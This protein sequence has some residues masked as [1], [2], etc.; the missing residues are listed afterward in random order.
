MSTSVLAT[1]DLHHQRVL[2]T[3]IVG[4]GLYFIAH[5][6]IRVAI[7]P[8]LEMDEAEQVFL[9]Q[10]W[11]LGYSPEP[12]PNPQP[13][14]YPW[15]QLACFQI[16]GVGV[17]A[18]SFLKNLLL[19][20]TF[21]LVFLTTRLLTGN[22]RL[23]V[24]AALSLFLFPQ[25]AWESQ[26]DLTHSVLAVMLGA[27]TLLEALYLS[28]AR[29]LS[30]YVL[31]GGLLGL[32][33]MSKYTFL[34]FASA[35]LLGMLWTPDTRATILDKRILVTLAVSVLVTLPHML[36]W[37]SHVQVV[38]SYIGKISQ[39]GDTS[40][41][42]AVGALLRAIVSFF[43]IPCLAYVLLFPSGFRPSQWVRT[44]SGQLGL[45]DRVLVLVLTML[46]AI[47]LLLVFGRFNQRWIQPLLWF[48]PIAFFAHL[49]AQAVSDRAWRWCV[50]G[51]VALAAIILLASAVRVVGL[52]LI[53]RFTPFAR[54]AEYRFLR[55]PARLNYPFDAIAEEVRKHGF[56]QGV[57]VAE[58]GILAGNL[59]LK[60]P[61]SL[62]IIPGRMPIDVEDEISGKS[63]L[64]IWDF[65]E[66]GTMP[67][68]I[69]RFLDE[70]IHIEPEAERV[71]YREFPFK[72]SASRVARI[73]LVF[74]DR[75]ERDVERAGSET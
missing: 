66:V 23:A 37:W 36:W 25:I 38:S 71:I 18:L 1:A 73:G 62:L 55:Y 51:A 30:S 52:P 7:S 45:L 29:T 70:R 68:H 61:D 22:V 32:G 67:E 63:V 14:L 46:G 57:I 21:L 15:L 58:N 28:R 43:I 50:R 42:E 24:L 41:L 2:R 64:A 54:T 6:L 10:W 3:L 40:R 44:T 48:F 11:L 31:F 49:P 72:Y 69:R 47:A 13:P 65:T 27:A 16:F 34:I 60:F 39:G 20:L 4:L 74:L 26:R 56:D 33:A 5:V 59:R 12:P 8:A 75:R 19:F 17:F 9:T 35:L 53:D